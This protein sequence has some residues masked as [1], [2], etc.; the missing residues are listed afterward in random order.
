MAEPVEPAGVKVEG[1]PVGIARPAGRPLER[2]WP[3]KAVAPTV[4]CGTDRLCDPVSHPAH[5]GQGL[6]G[7]EVGAGVEEV[8]DEAAAEIMR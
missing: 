8:R 4:P 1:E 6:D 5:A 3:A 7:G 2:R